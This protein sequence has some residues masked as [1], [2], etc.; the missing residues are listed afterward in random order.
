MEVRPLAK[1]CPVVNFINIIHTNFSYERHFGSFFYIHVTRKKAAETTF[2]QKIR[3]FIVDEID[4]CSSLIVRY[5]LAKRYLK[6]ILHFRFIVNL[7][8]FLICYKTQRGNVPKKEFL[9]IIM[10]KGYSYQA[11]FYVCNYFNVF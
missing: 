8:F 11:A 3:T 2:I 7:F 4:T 5:R 6:I 1:V 10:K 9:K